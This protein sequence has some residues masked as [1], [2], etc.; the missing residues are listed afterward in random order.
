MIRFSI[1]TVALSLS[2][3]PGFGQDEAARADL[4][5]AGMDQEVVLGGMG[6]ADCV[7]STHAIEVDWTDKWHEGLGQALSYATAT[8]LSPG[9][10]LIC[11]NDESLCLRHSL[12]AREVLAAQAIQSMIWECAADAR[13]LSDCLRRDIYPTS[14]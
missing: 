14:P 7:S 4:F 8:G 13:A 6:R 10:I 11:R 9:L 12:A 1:L 2:V 3:S 5:C